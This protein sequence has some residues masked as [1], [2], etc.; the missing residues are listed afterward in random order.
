MP[1]IVGEV[2]VQKWMIRAERGQEFLDDGDR[3]ISL[4]I[5]FNGWMKCDFGE[6]ENDG[7]LINHVKES[8]KFQQVFENIKNQSEFAELLRQLRMFTVMN[9]R[10]PNDSNRLKRYDGSFAS[11]IDVLYQVRCNL[12]H[13]RKDITDDQRDYELVQLSYKILLPLFKAYLSVHPL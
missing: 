8:A 13:G 5:A 3:F 2:F 12:F 11:L 10:Y 1:F 9:M 7:S 6:A 4:W